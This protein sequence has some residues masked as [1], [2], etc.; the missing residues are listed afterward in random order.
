[1]S[2]HGVEVN[3]LDC[4]I[5]SEIKL[6]SHYYVHFWTNPL[7]FPSYRLNSTTAVLQRGRLWN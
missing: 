6:Q 7:I 4:N 1:M 5:V 3:V 2:S